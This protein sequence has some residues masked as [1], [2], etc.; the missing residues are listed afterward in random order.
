MALYTHDLTFAALKN[1]KEQVTSN[2]TTSQYLKTLDHFIWLALGPVIKTC[3]NL[4]LNYVSKVVAQQAVRPVKMTSDDKHNLPVAFMNLLLARDRV[5]AAKDLHLNRGI[6]FSFLDIFV[7]L[8]ARYRRLHE[9]PPPSNLLDASRRTQL[10]EKV[11]ADLEVI[12]GAN[13]YGATLEASHWSKEAIA[14]KN[15]IVEKYTRLAIK[16]AQKTYVTAR[17]RRELGAIVNVFMITLYKAIDRCDSRHG[18]LSTFIT[19]WLRGARSKVLDE[20]FA[21]SAE[22]SYDKQIEDHGEEAFVQHSHQANRDMEAMQS[23]AHI[24]KT[25][26]P[27]GCVRASLGIAEIVSYRDIRLLEI[28]KAHD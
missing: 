26:D 14:F 9:M 7:S 16:G 15:V 11:E 21:E 12:P 13:L 22:T 25:I 3:P 23:L 5:T 28:L 1:I 4:F 20:V 18:V 24:A 2:Y 17:H 10:L 19:N 8:T 6:L 27:R